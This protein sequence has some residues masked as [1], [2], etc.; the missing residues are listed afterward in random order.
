MFIDLEEADGTPIVINVN[1]I[2][3]YRPSSS[4]E[5]VIF[6]AAGGNAWMQV[7][8]KA[9]MREMYKSISDSR[10]ATS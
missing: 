9:T 7:T 10:A 5:T 1:H 4:E 8:V 2:A 6:F 3:F